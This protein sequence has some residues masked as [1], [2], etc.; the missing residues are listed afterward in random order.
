MDQSLRGG[1]SSVTGLEQKVYSRSRLVQS[2]WTA[3]ISVDVDLDD[4]RGGKTTTVGEGGS[5][6]INDGGGDAREDAVETDVE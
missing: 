2:Q 5:G 4:G 1:T 3:I 6:R